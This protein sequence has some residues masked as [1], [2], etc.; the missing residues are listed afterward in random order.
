VAAWIA[1]LTSAPRLAAASRG[2]ALVP[3]RLPDSTTSADCRVPRASLWAMA[4]GAPV[5]FATAGHGTQTGG[6]LVQHWSTGVFL[7]YFLLKIQAG[8]WFN[9]GK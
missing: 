9:A 6:P 8:G 4:Y 7:Y 3:R 1:W 5:I 2:L